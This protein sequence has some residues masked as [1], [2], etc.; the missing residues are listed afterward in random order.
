MARKK[1]PPASRLP[2]NWTC[3]D[4]ATINR[5][6]VVVN[7]ELSFK[8]VKG[9]FRFKRLVVLD[10]GRHWIDVFGG[11]EKHETMRSFGTERVRTVHRIA[12]TRKNNT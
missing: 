11:P 3:F 5:K 2:S 12:K 4:E 9:R 6:K 1:N 10:D 8:G 7:T